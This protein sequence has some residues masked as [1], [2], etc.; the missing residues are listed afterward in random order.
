MATK[1]VSLGC[2]AT[3]VSTG[4][5]G[6][7]TGKVHQ[8]NGNV[9]WV[10]QPQSDDK[11]TLPDAFYIDYHFV[12]YKDKGVSDKATPPNPN[13]TILQLGSE[14]RDKVTGMQGVLMAWSLH[15][16]GCI[17]YEIHERRLPKF[18]GD[19]ITHLLTSETV[20]PLIGS[21]SVLETPKE[22]TRPPGGPTTRAKREKVLR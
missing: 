2:F 9:R 18:E 4:V 20:E 19:K 21:K 12:Q 17:F 14:V 15:M 3:D 6:M 8:L 22:T 16:N 13:A 7:I 11:K 1:E 5:V 10:M